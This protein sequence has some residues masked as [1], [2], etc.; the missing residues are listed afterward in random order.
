MRASAS[1][2][3]D[4]RG[5]SL[6]WGNLWNDVVSRTQDH[7]APVV[8]NECARLRGMH[9]AQ[10]GSALPW[11][12]VLR[13]E[14]EALHGQAPRPD[15][16]PTELNQRA[17]ATGQAAL[18][19]SGGG[20]RS[21]SFSLGV[22]QVLART[23]VLRQF[24]YLS[25]VS[26]GGFAGAWMTAWRQRAE[27]NADAQRELDHFEGRDQPD[28]IVEPA[29][30][31]QLRRYI[32]YMSPREGIFSADAWALAA[33]MMRN[34]LVNWLVLLPLIAAA[35]LV[36]RIL[37]SLVHAS[38]RNYTPGLRFEWGEVELWVLLLAG[39]L[40]AAVFVYIAADLPSYGNRR[41]SQRAF[42]TKCLLPLSLGTLALTYFWTIDRVELRLSTI[43][44]VCCA[45]HALL[46]TAVAAVVGKRKARPRTILAAAAAA[47][48]PAFG[49]YGMTLAF[50][51]GTELHPLF[52][53]TAFPMIIC[54]LLVGGM[55]FVGIA[56]QEFEAADLEWWSRFGGWMLITATAWLATS[57]VVFGGPVLFAVIRDA[58]ANALRLHSSHASALTALTPTA[59]GG[60]AALLSSPAFRQG[61][62]SVVRQALVAFAA[63]AFA[64]MFV[65]TISWIN[66]AL[67]GA[68]SPSP[69]W[70]LS[71]FAI[72]GLVG[73]LM[74]RLVP[75]NQ[76]SLSGMYG[77]RLVRAF[78]AAS[79]TP[80]DPNPFTGF[81][82]G[83]DL[84]LADLKNVR[85]LH[86]VNAT[87]E[88]VAERQLGQQERRA[89]PF[90]FTPLHAG[91]AAVGYRPSSRFAT[92][93]ATKRGVS[94]GTAITISGAAASPS[95]GMY[96]SPA[97]TFLMTLLNARLGSWVGNPGP[98]GDNTW[99]TAE[100]KRGPM[101]M[102]DELLGRTTD[103]RPYVYL[104]DGGHFDNLG[105]TEMVRRRCRFIVVV[106]GGA[107]PAY[108]FDDLANAVRRIRIDLGVRIEMDAIDMS[109][110]R[111][112]QGNPHCLTGRIHYDEVDGAGAVGTLVYLK[113]ALSGDEPSDVRNYAAAHPA[114]PHEST[115]NQWFSEAQFESYRM[116][117]IHTAE[118]VLGLINC[119]AEAGVVAGPSAL[120][121][122][123]LAYRAGITPADQSRQPSL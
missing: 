25:T 101:L 20:V 16:P 30:L 58:I 48:I 113:P 21:A 36:P 50:R 27:S 86:V 77:Q 40:M 76:F 51:N 116:L 106:D 43:L 47:A 22:L 49:L 90:T 8:V 68:V 54:L 73:W 63:P 94:L 87:L 37:Y 44:V 75:V 109:L 28:G 23:G 118:S 34:L 60:L 35:L 17:F 89:E 31:V 108:V 111:Q 115:L 3:A 88:M 42:L 62:R 67:V 85:P 53:V 121:A 61:R 38:D 83:D 71:L 57:G 19:L 26:G 1:P 114:F 120:C 64:L 14:M 33:T 93:P 52:V 18:C 66:Q 65:S 122:A 15:E 92:D 70:V 107:D 10:Q 98:A 105:L 74:S 78:I 99:M 100:P 2:E 55:L 72:F 6:K 82:Q 4:S 102:L 91:A 117:G 13:E 104:S 123:A 9:E 110:A 41:Q 81:D 69:S 12:R 11:E 119:S 95:M 46:W 5:P 45:G 80:R 59:L 39:A 97:K 56:G 24:A 7:T 96:S 103:T 84:P 29:P 112:G 79:R 32:R